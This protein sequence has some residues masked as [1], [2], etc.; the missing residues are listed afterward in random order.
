MITLMTL[1]V[2][3]GSA[4]ETLKAVITAIVCDCLIFALII[5]L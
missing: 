4:A 2:F 1:P 3:K 5:N